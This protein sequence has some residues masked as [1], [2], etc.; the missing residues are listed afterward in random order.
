MHNAQSTSVMNKPWVKDFLRM[1]LASATVAGLFLIYLFVVGVP[2][3]NARNFYNQALLT[4]NIHQKQRLLQ[5]SINT[6]Y[7]VD[8][9][10]EL[11]AVNELLRQE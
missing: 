7:S 9:D 11:T 10:K 3:T 8:T 5:E 6:W 4:S 2:S 1:L